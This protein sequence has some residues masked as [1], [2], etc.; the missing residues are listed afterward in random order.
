MKKKL[1]KLFISF[2]S[3]VICLGI[4]SCSKIFDIKPKSAVAAEQMYRNVYDADAA[5]I[6]VYGKFMGLAKQYTVLNELR[7][8]LTDVTANSDAY[9]KQ[10]STHSVK[11]TDNN[12]Y[13]DPRPFYAVIINC[14]DVL[15]NFNIM[16]SQHKMSVDQY[17]DRYSDVGALRSWLYLQLGIHFG[18]IPYVTNPI[19][20]LDDLQNQALFPRIGFDQLLDNLIQ[21]TEALPSKMPYPTGSSLLSTYDTYYTQKFFINKNTIIGD[22]NLWKGNFTKAAAAYREVVRIGGIPYETNPA[23]EQTYYYFR[24]GYEGNNYGVNWKTIFSTAFGE[25]YS[26]YEIM[27]NLPFDK[28]FSPNN[29]FIDLFSVMDNIYLNHQIWL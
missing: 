6:G 15:K 12:P 16:L 9:L 26:N 14:N 24:L 29:P 2:L 18:I 3:V 28:N 7:A 27:W 10:L 1:F 25:R 5:V 20:N 17:N 11:A 22:L 23:S 8:D 13:A 21:F 4:V 19:A